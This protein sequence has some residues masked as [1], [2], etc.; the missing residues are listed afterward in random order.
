M[1]T[2]IFFRNAMYLEQS[3]AAVDYFEE[4]DS[5]LF[6][7]DSLQSWVEVFA[8]ASQEDT[9]SRTLK[10]MDEVHSQTS[11]SLTTNIEPTENSTND[12]AQSQQTSFTDSGLTLHKASRLEDLRRFI[13]VSLLVLNA[14]PL[15][16]SNGYFRKRKQ[17]GRIGSCGSFFEK[18]NV[19]SDILIISVS[20]DNEPR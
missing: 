10:T 20:L 15:S 17:E 4:R 5:S 3:P 19:I 11:K 7:S 9:E 14:I 6:L 2:S 18:A 1:K 8:T 13:S 16:M 12:Q